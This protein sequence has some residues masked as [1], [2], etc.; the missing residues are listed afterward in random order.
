VTSRDDVT[1]FSTDERLTVARFH[2]TIRTV[3]FNT[4]AGAFSA[5]A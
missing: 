2:E 1:S 4:A 3:V 5:V